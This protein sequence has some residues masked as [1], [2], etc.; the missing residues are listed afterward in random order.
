[1]LFADSE[2][3]YFY[4]LLPM[5]GD[6]VNG[7]LPGHVVNMGTGVDRRRVVFHVVAFGSVPGSMIA[8]DVGAFIWPGALALSSYALVGQL[9]YGGCATPLPLAGA[10][11]G[12]Y[13]F[14]RNGGGLNPPAPVR[15]CNSPLMADTGLGALFPL[16]DSPNAFANRLVLVPADLRLYCMDSKVLRGRLGGLVCSLND[17]GAWRY[18]IDSC[19]SPLTQ[20]VG[21]APRQLLPVLV[22]NTKFQ[23]TSAPD[24]N[25]ANYLF[26]DLTGPW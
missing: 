15:F 10:S 2:Q 25:Q 19:F 21:G 13:Q 16:I 7:G 23:D 6:T 17:R 12:I 9:S 26:F 22:T 1:L 20:N 11:V 14:Y 18:G 24:K 8:G 5:A 3:D 4:L